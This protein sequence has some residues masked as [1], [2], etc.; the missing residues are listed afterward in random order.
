MEPSNFP[1]TKFFT[2]T[3]WIIVAGVVGSLFS[4]L[5]LSVRLDRVID[6]IAQ[7]EKLRDSQPDEATEP[8]SNLPT[9]ASIPDE[10]APIP[11]ELRTAPEVSAFLDPV[12]SQDD[13]IEE[14]AQALAEVDGW[15]FLPE[16]EEKAFALMDEKV[17]VLRG[18]I[19]EKVNSLD[20]QA[21]GQSEGKKALGVFSEATTLLGLLPMPSDDSAQKK[22]SAVLERRERS[23]SFASS[24][25]TS[26]QSIDWKRDMRVT[27]LIRRRFRSGTR[28]RNSWRVP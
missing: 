23:R 8:A 21:L 28:I 26:G 5:Y 6:S 1:N 17:E 22:F 7:T 13:K 20:V 3:Q 27:T 14:K 18:I 19:L 12:F 15:L 11:L 2:V 10:E 16:E 4:S 9:E 24:A 25:T